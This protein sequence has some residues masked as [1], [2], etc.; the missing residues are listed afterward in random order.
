MNKLLFVAIVGDKGKG[1]P[2]GSSATLN[3]NL[4]D[5]ELL[6]RFASQGEIEA[7]KSLILKYRDLVYVTCRRRL[8]SDADA[9]D[10]TQQVFLALLKNAEK[11]HTNISSWL[12]RCAVSQAA[13]TI[14]SRQRRLRCEREKARM[15]D[16]P[17]RKDELERKEAIVILN[18]CLRELDPTHR[19][20]ILQ[21]IALQRPQKEIAASLG[22]TQQA[23]AK[24][25]GKAL[26]QL[27]RMLIRK[28]VFLSLASAVMLLGKRFIRT[29][30]PQS[31]RLKLTT[32]AS[33]QTTSTGTVALSTLGK[34]KLAATV[35]VVLTAAVMY[36]PVA[37]VKPL[38]EPPDQASAS[39]VNAVAKTQ[40]S[41]SILPGVSSS[42]LQLDYTVNFRSFGMTATSGQIAYRSAGTTPPGVLA[43]N[44]DIGTPSLPFQR[45]SIEPQKPDPLQPP[46]PLPALPVTAEFVGYRPRVNDFPRNSDRESKENRNKHQSRNG[47]RKQRQR[48]KPVE[49]W[50]NDDLWPPRGDDLAGK[51]QQLPSRPDAAV[52]VLDFPPPGIM[53]MPSPDLPFFD[54]DAPDFPFRQPFLSVPPEVILTQTTFFFADDKQA[55]HLDVG[56][57]PPRIDIGQ[58]GT[59]HAAVASLWERN[60]PW[61]PDFSNNPA[62]HDDLILTPKSIQPTPEPSTLSFLALSLTFLLNRRRRR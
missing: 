29:A 1:P 44:A 38:P 33:T 55:P 22:V 59:I 26:T 27:R 5:M 49:P 35:A 21:N 34:V 19:E 51:I 3:Y 48:G 62:P 57:L 42:G 50:R 16:K 11:I 8:D 56:L 2:F 53:F 24:R 37:N 6:R 43:S 39:T 7:I 36:E 32:L 23:V 52:D 54:Y 25:I 12:Y 18:E 58:P 9:E 28:G 46:A 45:K 13:S 17:R 14:R 60:P 4:D 30:F 61:L 41:G 20:V 15:T 40:S 31:L 47:L 10:A